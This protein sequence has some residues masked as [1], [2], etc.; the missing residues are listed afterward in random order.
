MFWKAAEDRGIKNSKEV[1]KGERR[2]RRSRL[3][4]WGVGIRRRIKRKKEGSSG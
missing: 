3:R 1:V 4:D 2:K